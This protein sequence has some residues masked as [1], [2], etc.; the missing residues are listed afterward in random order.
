MD[1]RQPEY[2]QSGLSSPPRASSKRH[3]SEGSSADQ[4]SA[5]P[6]PSSQQDYK[7]P[8][9]YSTSATPSS[10]YGY[11][12]QQ[13]HHQSSRYSANAPNGQH[14]AGMAQT[15]SP[16]LSNVPEGNQ[17]NGHTPVNNVKSDGQLPID[18][19]IAQSSPTYP[20]PHNYS[21]YPPQHEMP[22]YPNQQ[23]TYG[24]PDWA[25]HYP[26][27]MYGGS[28]ATTAGGAPNMV[29]HVPRPPA[30]RLNPVPALSGAR[31]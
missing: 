14:A 9:G 29:A 13:S 31:Y 7:P 30:V 18:P 24:R 17:A 26:S 2:S 8:N 28:P 11:S 21:P 6:Y 10:D 12:Q 27:P 1:G 22:Q 15:S 3:Y 20:P 19:S 4:P 16:S 5:V 23:M 25:G